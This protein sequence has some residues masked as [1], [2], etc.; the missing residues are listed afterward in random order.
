MKWIKGFVAIYMAV[1]VG[2]VLSNRGAPSGGDFCP[3][4][5]WAPEPRPGMTSPNWAWTRLPFGQERFLWWRADR[6]RQ[7]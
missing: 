6:A 2:A 7:Q 3:V 4:V 5:C 1:V